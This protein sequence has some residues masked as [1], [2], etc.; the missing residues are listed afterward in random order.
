MAGEVKQPL[1]DFT[2][3]EE[4]KFRLK[5]AL[6]EKLKRVLPLAGSALSTVSRSKAQ[7]VP[8]PSYAKESKEY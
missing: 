7:S 4:V 2:H 8:A 3:Y 6:K 1:F 5:K